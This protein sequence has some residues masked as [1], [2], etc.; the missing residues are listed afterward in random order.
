MQ[1][2]GL[3]RTINI[4]W[5]NEKKCGYLSYHIFFSVSSDLWIAVSLVLCDFPLANDKTAAADSRWC[6]LCC[7]PKH[8]AEIHRPA[9]DSGEACV[10][11]DDKE[12]CD[13][14]WCV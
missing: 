5:E 2:E 10:G 12:L 1:I 9:Q 4:M 13:T 11:F 6:C 7:H 8:H 14:G 3:K